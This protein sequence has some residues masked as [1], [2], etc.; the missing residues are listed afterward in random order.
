MSQISVRYFGM[1]REVAGRRQ[2][3][4]NIDDSSSA[5]ELIKLL[6]AKH[7]QKFTEFIFDPRGRLRQGFAF[8]VNGHSVDESKLQGIKCKKIHEFVILPPISGGVG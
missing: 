1:L 5:T 6:S 3:V 4:F 2:E 7:G 8:A